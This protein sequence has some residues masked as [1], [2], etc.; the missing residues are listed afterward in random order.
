MGS[1]DIFDAIPLV[2]DQD[3]HGRW[4]FGLCKY[5]I[6]QWTRKKGSKPAAYRHTMLTVRH[7]LVVTTVKGDRILGTYTS[8]A[9]GKTHVF[10][11]TIFRTRDKRDLKGLRGEGRWHAQREDDG[12]WRL[13]L[14]PSSADFPQMKIPL[15][16]LLKGRGD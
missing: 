11:P 8:K 4:G 3:G 6:A 1:P 14:S 9:T 15:V 7:Q 12:R 2:F 16:F 10:I 13:E 5:V